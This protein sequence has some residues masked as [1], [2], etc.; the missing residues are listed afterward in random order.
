MVGLADQ[1]DF[2]RIIGTFGY[3]PEDRSATIAFVAEKYVPDPAAR[4]PEWEQPS[5]EYLFVACANLLNKIISSDD[6]LD[7]VVI[8]AVH[9]LAFLAA[10]ARL[11]LVTKQYRSSPVLWIIG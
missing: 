8:G 3:A 2:A 1:G 9:V 5:S 7:I 10:F 6:K 11:L 4:K